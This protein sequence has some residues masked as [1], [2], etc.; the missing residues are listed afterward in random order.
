M[1]AQPEPPRRSLEVFRRETRRWLEANCPPEMRQPVVD[2]TD[3]CWGGR[4]G[5]SRT[6]RRSY[7]WRRMAA[8]G[9]TVPEWP[10]AYGGG[11]LSKDEARVLRE[12]MAALHCR[13][14]LDFVRYFD[15]R[16]RAA[17]VRQRSAEAR[18]HSENRARRDSLVPGIL[19]TGRR[20]RSRVAQ[21]A[22]GRSRAITSSST[23]RRSGPATATRPIGF[24]VSC[25]PTSNGKKQ[26]GISFLLFDMAS[27]RASRRVRFV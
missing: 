1:S 12:E 4:N 20:L 18:A 22:R 8:R 16:P 11:G 25:A 7:G 3:V 10:K 14:P 17:E 15:A 24:S 19:G 2:E 27:R 5:S 6:T 21:D 9:W 23:A 13:S 26:E